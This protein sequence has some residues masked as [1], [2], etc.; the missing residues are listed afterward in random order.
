MLN[1]AISRAQL[2]ANDD[3]RTVERHDVSI[4][5]TIQDATLH[6]AR[7]TI[8]NISKQGLLASVSGKY[9]VG[10]YVS[11][12]LPFLGPVDAI[13]RWAGN[14]LVGCEFRATIGD[15]P[16]FGFLDRIKRREYA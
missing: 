7:V 4:Q 11:L 1:S 14:G 6:S 15:N 13:I 3:R 12:D 5:C 9:V 2:F 16:F 8:T 10:A